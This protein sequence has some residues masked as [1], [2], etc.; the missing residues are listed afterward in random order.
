MKF[1]WQTPDALLLLMKKEELHQL[2]GIDVV[3]S[4]STTDTETSISW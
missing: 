4:L 3:R 1:A 2:I